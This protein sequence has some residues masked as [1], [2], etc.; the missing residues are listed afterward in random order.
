MNRDGWEIALAE[1][2]VKLRRTDGTLDEDD[3]LIE[4]EVIKQ[5]VELAVLLTLFERYEVL[6]KT[7]QRQLGVFV[8]VMLGR[9]LHELAADGL[10]LIG[11]GGAEH[12]DLLL[13]RR[14]PEDLLDVA[15]HVCAWSALARKIPDS[16]GRLEPYQLGP[17]SCHTHP[18]R[19]CARCPDAGTCRE[20]ERSGGRGF[21]Q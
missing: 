1:Q 13:L 18:A 15:S 9:V 5:L 2:L 21:R 10:D 6:L 14:G 7:V 20:Q 11:K 17:T 19:R 16:V 4:L 8:N 12:H 3:D